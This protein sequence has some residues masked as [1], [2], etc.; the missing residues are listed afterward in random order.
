MTAPAVTTS[1]ASPPMSTS[2]T[3]TRILGAVL[4]VSIAAVTWLAFVVSKPD[5]E[6]G[7]TVRLL[8]VHPPSATTAYL[9]CFVCAAGSAMYLWKRSVWWDLV[10]ASSAEIGVVFT[11]L[12]LVTG[13]LW[14]KPTWGTYWQWDARLTTTLLLFLM[15]LG[16]LAL[17]RTSF[18]AEVS[19]K[20]SAIVGL[21]LV[22]N[23]IIVNRSVEWWRTIHQKTT[24]VQLDPKI[25]GWQLFT[26]FAAML[27]FVGIFA[28]LL[29]HRFRVAWLE[30]QVA[31]HGLDEALAERRAEADITTGA[32][33]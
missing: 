4:L 27:V 28:W 31:E 9:A 24:L 21:L 6:L 20:R 25:E 29:I 12:A 33:R 19:A 22:P 2:S 14:G 17:R 5:T 11:A 30:R 8:Y 13:M 15:L 26:F 7:Q 1:T 16:Y 10:A 3:T 32:E 18:D 23:V